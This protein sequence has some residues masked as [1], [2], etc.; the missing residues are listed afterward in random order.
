MK[1]ASIKKYNIT[2]VDGK[3]I[4]IDIEMFMSMLVEGMTI[5]ISYSMPMTMSK[6]GETTVTVPE[7]LP[8]D[9]VVDL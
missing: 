6:I 5:E 8:V 4:S 7:N 2:L 3:I 9:G 1:E